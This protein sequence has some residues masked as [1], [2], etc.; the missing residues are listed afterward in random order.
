MKAS[1]SVLRQFNNRFNLLGNGLLLG[2]R[3]T[4]TTH[5]NSPVVPPMNNPVE[6]T[7]AASAQRPKNPSVDI[8][9]TSS[10]TTGGSGAS[11]GPS[12][13]RKTTTETTSSMPPKTT[14]PSSSYRTD[15]ESM[16]VLLSRKMKKA[17]ELGKARKA[18]EHLDEAR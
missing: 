10:T 4:F 18:L 8:H 13:F 7:S 11:G 2:Q 3:A 14:S 5:N 15:G 6:P 16:H 17:N 12:S 9:H 1:I